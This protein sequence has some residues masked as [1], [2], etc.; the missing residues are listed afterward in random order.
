MSSFQIFGDN[1]DHFLS[2]ALDLLGNDNYLGE[3]FN[4]EDDILCSQALDLA[5][6][7]S[8]NDYSVER[9]LQDYDI[10]RLYSDGLDAFGDFSVK[11]ERH[12]SGLNE[13]HSD[14]RRYISFYFSRFE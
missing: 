9:M 14:P 6:N 3:V 12:E 10:S 11:F 13:E 4:K 8:E 2:Q 1:D 7:P 5:E